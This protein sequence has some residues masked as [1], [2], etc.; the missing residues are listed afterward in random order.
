M[1]WET[2]FLKNHTRNV[3][4]KLAQIILYKIKIKH[5]SRSTVWNIINSL[6][7][8]KVCFYWGLPKYIK[9]KVLRTCFQKEVWSQSL[10]LIFCKMFEGKYFSR[11][12]LSTD[13]ISWTEWLDFLRFY[14]LEICILEVFVA[15]S[16]KS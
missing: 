7:C 10:C 15:Q 9:T 2:F 5:I 14:I 1:M 12:F 3:V 16:M 4:E 13:E 6:K 11:Y 8:Y